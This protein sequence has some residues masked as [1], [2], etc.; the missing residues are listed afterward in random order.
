[1]SGMEPTRLGRWLWAA[2][3]FAAL[4]AAVGVYGAFKGA[5]AKLASARASVEGIK[6]RLD[7][8]LEQALA[9]RRQAAII[10]AETAALRFG[11]HFA[12]HINLRQGF[13]A[14]Q[15]AQATDDFALLAGDSITEQLYL[16]MVAGLPAVNGGMGGASI[17][18]VLRLLEIIPHS[19]PVKLV[20][21]EAGVN[22]AARSCVC[23]GFAEKWEATLRLVVDKALDLSPGG[24]AINTIIPVEPG[25][26]FAASF[27]PDKIL[28]FNTAIRKVAA[29]K[30]IILI[31]NDPVFVPLTAGGGYTSDGVHPNAHGFNLWR[32]NIR[33]ALAKANFR[34]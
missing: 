13:I 14:T 34:Q 28:A 10:S 23:P 20:V 1:M 26:P 12:G 5:E 8:S 3:G 15:T 31:D 4:L 27:D 19:S 2:A 9:I 16:P 18:D 22:D 24:V 17:A 33:A 6:P 30:K 11:M 7:A 32:E 29:E 25:K 21:L